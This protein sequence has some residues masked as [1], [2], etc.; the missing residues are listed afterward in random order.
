MNNYEK[1]H[2]RYTQ[3]F[4]E[5]NIWH[6]AR[7]L[8]EHNRGESNI[9]VMLITNK[10]KHF[11]IFN[12]LNHSNLEYT[13]WDYHVILKAQINNKD[14]IFDFDSTLD[15][16]SPLGEYMQKSFPGD[17]PVSDE[18]RAV[19]RV[20]PAADYVRCFYSD[21]EHMRGVLDDELFPDTPIIK[22]D[23]E[24]LRIPLSD[25]WDIVKPLHDSS[26]V[27]PIEHFLNP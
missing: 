6:L 14:Y 21:R 8:L 18:F 22:P 15:F 25:Y 27:Y 23:D 9:Q 19:V 20:I 2:Y 5:E 13:I 11:I 12:Q 4:C 26:R 3:Y 1:S 24:K 7:S 10:D 16:P 17:A